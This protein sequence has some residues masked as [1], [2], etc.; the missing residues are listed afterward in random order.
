MV[1]FDC[2]G[3]R[4]Y[5]DFL[6]LYWPLVKPSGG[7]VVL[8]NTLNNLH[9]SHVVKEKKLEQATSRFQEY[10][11]LSILEPQKFRQNSVTV[12]RRTSEC[13]D[14]FELSDRLQQDLLGDFL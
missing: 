14:D 2:G 1:W 11:L 4:D 13:K 6:E 3:Y 10:E 8:H 7:L 12:L 9:L 5:V